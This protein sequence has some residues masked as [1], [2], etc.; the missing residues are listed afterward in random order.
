MASGAEYVTRDVVVSWPEGLGPDTTLLVAL[1]AQPDTAL[2]L[3]Y[4]TPEQP[5]SGAAREDTVRVAVRRPYLF[6]VV[7]VVRN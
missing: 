3:P 4:K 1:A 5:P 6:E 7:R 2:H